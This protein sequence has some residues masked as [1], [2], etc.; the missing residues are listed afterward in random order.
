[1]LAGSLG[2]ECFGILAGAQAGSPIQL[3]ID[4]EYAGALKRFARGFAVDEETLAFDLIKEIGPGGF[5]T[6]SE[7][8]LKHY[9][10]EHWQPEIF[11]REALNA[12]LAGGRKT[13]IERATEICQDILENYHPR[14]ID[15]RTEKDLL[16][17]IESAKKEIM[18]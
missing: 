10:E 7:H 18:K 16:K 2:L 6:G 1:V 11:S 5:F 15:D 17:V 3:V 4:N 9:R 14:G 8:T 13:E 12:W